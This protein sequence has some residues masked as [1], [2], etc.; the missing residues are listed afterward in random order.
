LWFGIAAVL[1]RLGAHPAVDAYK[2]V[3]RKL[4]PGSVVPHVPRLSELQEPVRRWI[5]LNDGAAATD[6]D[7]ATVFRDDMRR[8]PDVAWSQ[9]DTWSKLLLEARLV[10]G[11]LEP[12]WARAPGGAPHPQFVSL[13]GIG[14]GGSGGSLP[15]GPM[16]DLYAVSHPAADPHDLDRARTTREEEFVVLPVVYMIRAV[17]ARMWDNVL[18]VIG[19]ILLLLVTHASYPFQ[20]NRRLEGFLWTDV[21]AGVAAILFVF[22]KMERDEVLSNIRSTTPGQIK[23]DRDFIMKLLV[24]GLI[25]VAGLFATEFPDIGG[26]V[27]GWIEPVRKALP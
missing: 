9:T 8:D 15:T 5:Q 1:E 21:A 26:T 20:M 2:R 7:L 13:A 11:V 24:Y 3:P 17:L 10:L 12:K 14:I 27:L 19:A 6:G 22:V 16:P 18:F 4:F 25:P 23:W